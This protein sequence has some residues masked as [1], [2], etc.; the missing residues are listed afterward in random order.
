ML[1]VFIKILPLFSLRLESLLD[2]GNKGVKIERASFFSVAIKFI[3]WFAYGN[4]NSYQSLTFLKSS[5]F[6]PFTQR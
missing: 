4:I 3:R 6:A 2:I 1:N 5:P